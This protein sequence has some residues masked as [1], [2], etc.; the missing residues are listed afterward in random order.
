MCRIHIFDVTIFWV[1]KRAIQNEFDLNVGDEIYT[2]YVGGAYIV[3][4]IR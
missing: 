2:F 4:N 3:Q 1:K